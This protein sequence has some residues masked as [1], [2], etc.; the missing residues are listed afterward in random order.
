[1]GNINSARPEYFGSFAK[2]IAGKFQRLRALVDHNVTSGDYHEE[3][4]RGLLRTFLPR[5]FSVKKGFVLG[6]QGRTSKQ[7][8]VMIVDENV[9]SAYVYQEGNFAVVL[10]GAVAA[11]MEVKSEFDAT[12]FDGAIENIASA[13]RLRDEPANLTGIIFAFNTT[14]ALTDANLQGWFS[15]PDVR[16]FQGNEVTAPEALLFFNQHTLL[17]RSR[18]NSIVAEGNEYRLLNAAGTPEEVQAF[19]LSVVLAMT[20]NACV[21]SPNDPARAQALVQADA[22]RLSNEAYRFGA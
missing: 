19:Q 3:V 15:R 11:V 16:A 13:K 17:V 12:K 8:D 1:M 22:G 9:A 21:R 14:T 5:R 4:M 18:N 10:P 6:A 20:I 2:E 7:I